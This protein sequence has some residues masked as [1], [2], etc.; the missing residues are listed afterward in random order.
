M[1]LSQKFS[2][3]NACEFPKSHNIIFYP[4][5]LWYCTCLINDA[6]WLREPDYIL[7]NTANNNMTKVLQFIIYKCNI[8]LLLL[9]FFLLQVLP[10]S[11]NM[12][13]NYDADFLKVQ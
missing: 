4:L 12:T 13:Q 8:I 10:F 5:G 9:N 3:P 11:Q 1:F 2:F 7:L 6:E